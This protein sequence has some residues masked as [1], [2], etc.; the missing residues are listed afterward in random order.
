MCVATQPSLP[1]LCLYTFSLLADLVK[2]KSPTG[3]TPVT[4][5]NKKKKKKGCIWH[6]QGIAFEEI[7]KFE[8]D[9]CWSADCRI[10]TKEALFDQ[11][12]LASTSFAASLSKTPYIP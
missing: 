9:G 5:Y 1:P 4:S 11:I 7:L 2:F 10:I 3:S 6:R 12:A 8:K